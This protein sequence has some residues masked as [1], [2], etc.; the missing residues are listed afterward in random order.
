MAQ[1]N[2][3]DRLARVFDNAVANY[4]AEE[5]RKKLLKEEEE[6]R[7]ALRG[8]AMKD[9]DEARTYA[10]NQHTAR[11]N[12]QLSDLKEGR[13]YAETQRGVIRKENREDTLWANERAL[14]ASLV[15][16]GLLSPADAQDPAKVAAAWQRLTPEAKQRVQDRAQAIDDIVK[17]VGQFGTMDIP[18]AETPEMLQGDDVFRVAGALRQKA[19]A[20]KQRFGNTAAGLMQTSDDLQ[21]EYN[22]VAQL[23]D[24]TVTPEDVQAAA[25]KYGPKAAAPEYQELIAADAEKIATNRASAASARARALAG[26]IN[27][28][29][30]RLST[31]DNLARAG[32]YLP[33]SAPATAPAAPA[34]LAQPEPEGDPL[35]AIFNTPEAKAKR[36]AKEAQA[37][38]AAEEKARLYA[39]DP[40]AAQAAE[41]AKFS[42]AQ[43]AAAQFI[44]LYPEAS[45]TDQQIAD[46]LK[47]RRIVD[48]PVI[49][50]G[51]APTVFPR[52]RAMTNA[53]KS[54]AFQDAV[55]PRNAKLKEAQDLVPLFK[56]YIDKLPDDQKQQLLKMAALFANPQQ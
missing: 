25:R 54:A 18:G 8:E 30:S 32:V 16:E 42:A 1:E 26:Q 21:A 28:T 4:T 24:P 47:D 33:E 9:R 12:E 46:S 38:A 35:D 43:R 19:A 14:I 41:D 22:Q 23:I 50:F 7:L 2:P 15:Q 52:S 31:L 49:S 36:A 3:Y 55:T 5:H 44:N 17:M 27:A 11:R 40:F 53:E 10:E 34:A 45:R 29:T 51:L 6:R 37:K 13:T 48:N 20:T 56:D 39:A